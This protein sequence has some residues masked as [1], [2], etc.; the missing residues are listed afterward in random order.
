M[1]KDPAF[2]FYPGDYLRDTQCLS[3]KV[4]VS[5]D[6]IMCEHMRNI[7]ISQK[8][9]NFFTKRLTPEE[10]EELMSVLTEINGGFQISWVAES[11]NKR[12]AYSQSRSKNRA[13]KSTKSYDE[14]MNNI[15]KSY[16]K[17]MENEIVINNNIGDKINKKDEILNFEFFLLNFE[18]VSHGK[19]EVPG[20]EN[21]TEEEYV[22][23]QAFLNLFKDYHHFIDR[24]PFPG[25]KFYRDRLDKFGFEDLQAGVEKMFALGVKSNMDLGL[26]L[27]DCIGWVREARNKP[28]KRSEITT[29]DRVDSQMETINRV[30]EMRKDK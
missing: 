21:F 18:N 2:L 16:D 1:A 22:R 19:S 29:K 8:Q 5:Y 23:F 3:E 27:I 30:M 6:R 13:G 28:K 9:L 12:K 17:H 11:I 24:N 4:Q 25:I 14:H 7:C 20:I 15:S 10:V 26:R